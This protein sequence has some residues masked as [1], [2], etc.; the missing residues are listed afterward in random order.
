MRFLF[1]QSHQ[2]LFRLGKRRERFGIQ[3]LRVDV[4]E[5][6]FLLHHAF[7]RRHT[8]NDDFVIP[9]NCNVPN[10]NGAGFER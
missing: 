5:Q 9:P 7:C 1:Q 8:L 3:L 4:F 2:L 10:A 6:R